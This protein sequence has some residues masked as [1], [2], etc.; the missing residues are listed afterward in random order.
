MKTVNTILIPILE[1]AIK[2]SLEDYESRNEGDSLGDLYLHYDKDENTLFFYDDLD[3]LLN[4]VQ[5]PKGQTF[6]SATFRFVL[7]QPGQAR[8]FE[9]DYIFKPFTISLV[10]KD[11]VVIEELFFLDDDT[12]HISG[13]I[14]GNIEK[15]LDDF[16]TDL[17]H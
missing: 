8:L 1:I 16:L 9:K 3:N 15:E 10:N 6:N 13:D 12:I 14:W 7:Q 4:K 2:E 5:L 11:L 17:M